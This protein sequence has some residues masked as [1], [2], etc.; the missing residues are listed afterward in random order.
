MRI[1][2]LM[3]DILTSS[4]PTALSICGEEYPINTDFRVWIKLERTL[5]E[6]TDAARRLIKILSL[7]FIGKIPSD[8]GAAVS[9]ISAFLSPF[10]SRGRGGE[11]EGERLF[12]FLADGGYIYAAF[13]SQ[14][15]IDLTDA[16]LHW[17]KF[18]ALFSALEGCKFTEIIKIR[19]L[20]PSELQSPKQKR[21][22]RRLKRLYRL[23]GGDAALSAELS[24]LI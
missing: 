23:D 7:V 12:D 14:Y 2:G 8:L 3:I 1:F 9:A 24:K 6:E 20:S 13:L 11:G 15:G 19:G 21:A 16:S 10:P 5:R 4:L 18:L 17:W 22:L